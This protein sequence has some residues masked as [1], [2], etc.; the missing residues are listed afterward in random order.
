MHVAAP[1]ERLIAGAAR[2]LPAANQ[3][4]YREEYHSELW[5]MAAAGADRHLQLAY[6]IRQV[7]RTIPLR[8]AVLAPR[9]RGARP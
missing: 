2:L 8:V 6:A 3:A 1:A 4:R 9:R 7:I 5:E